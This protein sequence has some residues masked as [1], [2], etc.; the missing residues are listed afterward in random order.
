MD[1]KK[2]VNVEADKKEVAKVTAAKKNKSDAGIKLLAMVLKKPVQTVFILC[3]IGIFWVLISHTIST[4]SKAAAMA[5]SSEKDKVAEAVYQEYYQKSYDKSEKK[6]HV[7]NEVSITIGNLKEEEKLEVLRISEVEYITSEDEEGKLLTNIKNAIK[8]VFFS[9]DSWLKVPA[10]GVFTVDLRTS[11]F[12]FDHAR[13]YVLI[14]IPEPKITSFGIDYQNVEL[15]HFENGGILKSSAKI[16]ESLAQEQLQ[17]AELK[18]W[19]RAEQ[20][21]SFYQRAK[22][23]AETT[24]TNLVKQLNPEIPDLVVEIEYID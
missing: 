15:L 19:Q 10:S 18:L 22:E 5:Y 13:S 12:I 21:Q 16:G 20:T 8:D 9:M 17:S 7:S 4:A 6:H 14:R 3:L 24:L 2:N 23:S 11:E 1:M